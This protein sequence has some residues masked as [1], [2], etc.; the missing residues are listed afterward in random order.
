MVLLYTTIVLLFAFFYYY[1]FLEG[2][3]PAGDNRV[4]I[5]SP[6]GLTVDVFVPVLNASCSAAGQITTNHV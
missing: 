2:L 3:S 1:W 5:T 6:D 4:V